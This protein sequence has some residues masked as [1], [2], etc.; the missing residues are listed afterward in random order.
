MTPVRRAGAGLI[1]G[2]DRVT[3]S[4]AEG[5]R[6]RRWREAV[7]GE[8]GLRHVLLLETDPAG[9]F[10][11]LELA[12]PAGLLTLHPED[13][14]T[15]HGNAID[16]GG[17]RHVTGLPWDA[18]GVVLL[19][20]SPVAR[21]AVAFLLRTVL[22]PGVSTAREAVLLGPD[23]QPALRR[24]QVTRT[25]AD[26]WRTN[27]DAAFRV[28]ADCLPILADGATWAMEAEPPG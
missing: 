10:T 19:A 20:G 25:D 3:W 9:R 16:A 8:Q 22:A 24:V 18:G 4:V 12:T 21:A 15:L 13:D 11:H 2:G 28:D 23:L 7:V 14:D 17:L 27:D 1:E 6:G 5:S 26:R